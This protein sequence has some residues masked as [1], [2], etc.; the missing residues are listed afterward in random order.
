MPTLYLVLW[1]IALFGFAS[2]YAYKKDHSAMPYVVLFVLEIPALFLSFYNE[3]SDSDGLS[4]AY[5]YLYV[6]IMQI[7]ITIAVCVTMYA[8]EIIKRRTNPQAELEV[9][10]FQNI[11]YWLWHYSLKVKVK[12]PWRVAR[13]VA[14]VLVCSYL[15]LV[16]HIVLYP[17]I[18]MMPITI[19]IIFPIVLIVDLSQYKSAKYCIQKVGDTLIQSEN[20]CILKERYDAIPKKQILK[21]KRMFFVYLAGAIIVSPCLFLEFVRLFSFIF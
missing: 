6:Y 11:H 12:R 15:S 9:T 20:S 13:I 5:G 2:W 4:K 17:I 3:F 18:I 1:V 8:C 16:A 21:Y 19:L 14:C 7:I 10:F